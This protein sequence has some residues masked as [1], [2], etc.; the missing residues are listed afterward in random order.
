MYT[1]E[2]ARS[3]VTRMKLILNILRRPEYFDL[4]RKILFYTCWLA[5]INFFLVFICLARL[6]LCDAQKTIFVSLKLYQGS[7]PVFTEDRHVK[8]GATAPVELLDLRAEFFHAR[9]GNLLGDDGKSGIVPASDGVLQHGVDRYTVLFADFS[10]LSRDS[11]AVSVF[12]ADEKVGL[13]IVDELHIRGWRVEGK[14]R[15]VT[16]G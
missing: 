13:V 16:L 7:L 5:I 8:R 12:Q 4:Q 9:E 10:A 1:H 14:G 15:L 6:W 3:K 2:S 11:E